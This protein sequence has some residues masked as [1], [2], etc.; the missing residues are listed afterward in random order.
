MIAVGHPRG[1]S[2]IITA[3]LLTISVIIIAAVCAM[4]AIS[5][6]IVATIAVMLTI[7][8]IIIVAITMTCSGTILANILVIIAAM[9][10]SHT[11]AA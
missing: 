2:L 11:K 3:A 1:I 8:A 5:A 6:I 7:P 10:L 9:F 4:V